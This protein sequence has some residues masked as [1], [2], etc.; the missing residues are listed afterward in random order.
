MIIV[1]NQPSSSGTKGS[2]WKTLDPMVSLDRFH[3]TGPRL[4]K[5]MNPGTM[6]M[7]LD[8]SLIFHQLWNCNK[9]EKAF[10][11]K[12]FSSSTRS[13]IVPS[14]YTTFGPRDAVSTSTIATPST[15][16]SRKPGWPPSKSAWPPG[17]PSGPL[18]RSMTLAM[19]ARIEL[20]FRSEWFHMNIFGSDSATRWRFLLP[21]YFSNFSND[22][23]GCCLPPP[24]G[25]HPGIVPKFV[26]LLTYYRRGGEALSLFHCTC[27]QGCA[28]GSKLGRPAG[29]QLL[30]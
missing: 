8:F 17:R 20:A 15:K 5:P 21:L 10:T 14:S 25:V 19:Q 22:W 4:D 11:C 2:H 28:L 12:S 6:L 7:K 26:V 29:A 9:F 13:G 16:S 18:G 23:R 3:W 27:C 30:Y 1:Y 24:K